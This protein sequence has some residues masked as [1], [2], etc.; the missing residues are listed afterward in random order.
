MLRIG[1]APFKLSEYT[2]EDSDGNA[3]LK[4]H[5]YQAQSAGFVCAR[6]ISSSGEVEL[7]GFVGLTSDPAG[8]GVKVQCSFVVTT[9]YGT[10]ASFAV[11]KGEYFE[12]TTT[13]ANAVNIYW[14][15]VGR[16]LKPIDFN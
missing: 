14:K 2:T 11:A 15:S 1:R 12:L 9:T 5:A 4:A 16:L 3:M 7:N 13:S 8:A 6:V 10:D